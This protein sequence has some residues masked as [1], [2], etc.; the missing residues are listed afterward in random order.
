MSRSPQRLLLRAFGFGSLMLAVVLGLGGSA[1]FAHQPH[2]GRKQVRE[3]ITDL[4]EQWRIATL[5]GDTAVMDKLLSDD[6]VGISWTGQ[7]NT[8]QMQLDRTRS[9]A[10]SITSLQL[11]DIKV[12]VVD[13]IAIVT[14]RAEVQGTTDGRTMDGSFRYTRV[15]QRLPSGA[16]KITNF[17]ATRIP[18]GQ[19]QR[20][21]QTP[22]PPPTTP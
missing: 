19:R 1:A 2:H 22:E 21:S 15:Y 16:W 17:E 7:V 12:K 8:K 13:S 6:Y 10:L 11:S 5:N 4:E 14:S 9:H 20:K 18:N 3:Q